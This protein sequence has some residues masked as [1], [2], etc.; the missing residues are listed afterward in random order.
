[1]RLKVRRARKAAHNPGNA[2]ATSGF[3]HPGPPNTTGEHGRSTPPVEVDFSRLY[4]GQ[5]V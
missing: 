2:R 1:M 4:P 3:Y 5:P